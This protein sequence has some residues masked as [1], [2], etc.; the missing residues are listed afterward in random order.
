MSEEHI[1]WMVGGLSAALQRERSKTQMT[2][3]DMIA[4]LR[5]MPPDSVV[6]NIREPCS[7]RGYYSDLAFSRGNGTRPAA[8]LLA[9]AMGC[10]GQIFSGYKGGEYLMGATT[11]VW[12]AEYG[13]CGD[14]LMALTARGEIATS[15]EP[16]WGES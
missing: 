7:Y 5:K 3:G 14:R 1:Q 4:A 13:E 11:P 16:A 15:P 6:A 2:L 9:E 8:D 12:I 10:M